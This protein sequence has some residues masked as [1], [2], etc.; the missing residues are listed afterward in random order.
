VIDEEK[1][2]MKNMSDEGLDVL[3]FYPHVHAVAALLDEIPGIE[4]YHAE[5]KVDGDE[6]ENPEPE[7]YF[8]EFYARGTLKGVEHKI[9]F[10]FQLNYNLFVMYPTVELP[11]LFTCVYATDPT[12]PSQVRQFI[13]INK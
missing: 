8:F 2:T 12:W 13:E 9:I 1:P 5:F 6:E 3:D 4:L 7:L 11:W 10:D